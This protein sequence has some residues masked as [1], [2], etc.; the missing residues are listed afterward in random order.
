MLG[1]RGCA[2]TP[3]IIKY[4]RSIQNV[5]SNEFYNK[6]FGG[7]INIEEWQKIEDYIESEVNQ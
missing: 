2:K 3:F 5:L 1:G 6:I 7:I 4:Y